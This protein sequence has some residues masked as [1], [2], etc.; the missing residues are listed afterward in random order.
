M[1]NK[2]FFITS[3]I[4]LRVLLDYVYI[5]R[6]APFFSYANFDYNFEI[7]NYTISWA[8]L[9]TSFSLILPFLKNINPCSSQAAIILYLIRFVPFTS[10][11]ANKGFSIGFIVLM[12]VFWV[13]FFLM[14]KFLPSFKLTY[15][16]TKTD[17]ILYGMLA[18]FSITVLYISG[19]YAHFRLNFDLF[20]VYDLR[21]E[22]RGFEL[23]I[24]LQYLWPASSNILPMIL[25]Y[26]ILKKKYYIVLFIGLVILLNFSINGSKST[27]FKMLFC[28]SLM[29]ISPKNVLKLIIIGC[30]LLCL[31]ADIVDS[32]TDVNLISNFVI[33]RVLFIPTLLDSLYYEYV[34]NSHPVFFNSEA[35][36]NMAFDLGDQYFGKEEMRCNNGLFT[37]AYMNL[38]TIGC[39]VFPFLFAILFKLCNSA[40]KYVNPAISVFATLL[41]CTTLGSATLTTSLFTH[42]LLLLIAT[43]YIISCY[44]HTVTKNQA[45]Y[46]IKFPS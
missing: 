6:I 30:P 16:S 11:I 18:I 7:T 13:I 33:R 37:D 19:V 40:F 25:V 34:N 31:L 5:Q 8:V 36:T 39:L 26:Y 9:I 17:K 1:C 44:N 14:L 15:I 27:L 3:V 23:P 32:L 46:C 38:G 35:V 4:L 10:M 41:I 22:A 2:G 29:F 42:G 12:L 21:M 28:I 24:I 20:N 43:G 45:F